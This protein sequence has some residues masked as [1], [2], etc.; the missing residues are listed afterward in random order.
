MNTIFPKLSHMFEHFTDISVYNERTKERFIRLNKTNF[1]KVSVNG[2][3]RI[4]DFIT[5]R[6]ELYCS[7]LLILEGEFPKLNK[8]KI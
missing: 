8:I 3:P 2:C 5:K 1:K 4:T 6:S 7:Y